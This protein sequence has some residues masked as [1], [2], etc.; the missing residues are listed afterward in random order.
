MIRLKHQIDVVV[1]I[2]DYDSKTEPIDTQQQ[3]KW[4]KSEILY[5]DT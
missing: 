3:Y 2:V 5:E 1:I 4:Q